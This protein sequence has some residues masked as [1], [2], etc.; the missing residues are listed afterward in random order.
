MCDLISGVIVLNHKES[1]QMS[2]ELR[3]AA[4]LQYAIEEYQ[5]FK[6]DHPTSGGWH[7]ADSRIT[8]PICGAY[9]SHLEAEAKQ[10]AED[11]QPITVEWLMTNGWQLASSDGCRMGVLRIE[12][13]TLTHHECSGDVIVEQG[14][15]EA[16]EVQIKT[17][18]ELRKLVEALG[19]K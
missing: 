11:E 3:A 4:K 5:N 15:N 6:C 12:G 14:F 17:V 7:C 1:N 9:L 13:Y 19:G 10:K 16:I 2:D 18:G 8:T